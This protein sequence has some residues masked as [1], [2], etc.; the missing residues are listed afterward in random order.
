[1]VLTQTVI[2]DGDGETLTTGD[3]SFTFDQ[4]IGQGAGGPASGRTAT[5][6]AE[7]TLHGIQVN[8]GLGGLNAGPD[9]AFTFEVADLSRAKSDP[10][11]LTIIIEDLP[12]VFEVYQYLRLDD[13][14]SALL[15]AKNY[16]FQAFDQLPFWVTDPNSPL[17]ELLG[18][19]TIPLINLTPRE[20]LDVIGEIEGS[21]DRV[22]RALR[23]PENDL[24][25]LVRFIMDSLGLDFE[26]DSDLFA[27]S[28]Q[29]GALVLSMR[30]EKEAE[31][32][33]PFNFDLAAFAGL[34]PGGIPGLD[35]IEDLIALE[36]SGNLN[37]K[38]FAQIMIEA[39]VDVSGR[40]KANLPHRW[41]SSFWTM[42][43]RGRPAPPM[44]PVQRSLRASRSW[45][46]TSLWASRSSIP[47]ACTPT[48]TASTTTGTGW[49]AWTAYCTPPTPPSTPTAMPPPIPN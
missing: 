15:R 31:K 47:S 20:L 4:I 41:T 45:P 19:T 23:D 9:A 26:T 40:A 5:G 37:L 38:A 22:Q 16:V 39:G 21:V 33:V 10:D 30:L 6:G 43:T 27:V 14:M 28:I 12:A 2:L 44:I 17:Y 3:R 13:L 1:M 25:K 36:G 8:T 7:A 29:A 42:T 35:R 18:D 49:V 34:I 24:Q 11:Y 48:T 32:N 46:G